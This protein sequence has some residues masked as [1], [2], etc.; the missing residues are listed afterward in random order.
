MK[1]S[2]LCT[3]FVI[4]LFFLLG[5]TAVAY[6]AAPYDAPYD[7]HNAQPQQYVRTQSFEVHAGQPG[8]YHI[9]INYAAVPGHGD[10]LVEVRVGDE[11]VPGAEAIAFARTFVDESDA[12]RTQQGNQVFPSQI[13]IERFSDFT[14]AATT[15]RPISAWLEA[16]Y[17]NLTF[18]VLEG[19]L[20]FDGEPTATLAETLPTYA[21]YNRQHANI[22]RIPS[23][24]IVIQAQEAEYKTSAALFPVNDRTCP[25]VTPYHH[26][27]ITLN[28]IGGNAWRVPGQRIQWAV[29]VP[30]AGMYRIAIRYVQREKRGFSSR[31]LSI[32]GEIPFQEAAELR[33]DFS[34]GFQSRF[35]AC[36]E[37]GEDFWFY[38][39]AGENLIGLEATL[40][41]FYEI[42]EIATQLL[43]DITRIYQEI[44]VIT[45]PTPDR[46]RDYQILIQ[47]PYFRERLTAQAEVIDYL[48]YRIDEAALGFAET[49]AILIRLHNHIT[50]LAA[51]PYRVNTYLSE[52]QNS[53]TALG[54]FITGAYE[55][56]LLIDVMGL[57]GE[58]AEGFRGR[59][60]V[61]RRLWHQL[62]V[63]LGS[64]TNDFSFDID[65][66][67]GVDPT[68]IE[69][70]V[71]TGFD[72]YSILIRLINERFVE[73]HPHINVDLRLVDAG[74]IFPAS[75][76]GT[77]P[78]VV[79]QAQAAMPINFAFRA[80][81]VDLTQFAGFDEVASRFAPAALETM[82]FRDAVYGLPDQMSFPV[83]FYRTDIL[84]DIGIY[85]PPSSMDELLGIV[86]ILQARHMDIFFTTVPQPQPGTGGGMV[87]AVTRQLNAVHVGMLHQMGGRAFEEDGAYTMV[88]DPIGI[89]AFRFWTDLYT[90]HNF[91]Y[92]ADAMT[93]FRMGDMPIVVTDLS[94]LNWINLAAPEIRGLW[95]I[96]PVPGMHNA[97]T[98]ELRHD[99]VISVSSNFIVGNMATRNDTLQESWEFLQ[100]FT[101]EEVQHRFAIDVEAVWGHNWRHTTANLAA[102]ERLGWGRQ[103][104]PVLDY[105]MD[106]LIAIPQVPGGY[107][108][109]REVHNAF[110]NVVVENGNPIDQL[111]IAR[112]RINRELTLKR[113]EFGLD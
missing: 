50:R 27:F 29:Y 86:P 48:L 84:A 23:D 92:L 21:E 109:G 13:E 85:Q 74:I 107:I 42:I 62:R 40:G 79:L 39:P 12:W 2:K 24:M 90:K 52:F 41:L 113:T 57:A 104:A 32:N 65:M 11:T 64:F 9:T 7:T 91:V 4:A 30:E 83:M 98:G 54:S 93:R 97:S 36:P 75:V 25:L 22:Q 1:K 96:A 28:T 99:T 88:A 44:V 17:N 94:M 18:V 49:N 10:I 37:T 8:Y 87:G 6:A 103:V 26:T 112:D 16:G 68:N 66:P 77:G 81:A 58:D 56:P 102:F 100:W 60:N 31:A 70:W 71:A 80:G 3:G 20:V 33:F 95:N 111:F 101:S 35:L 46:H 72:V 63:F 67:A 82:S 5:Y 106:W 78:D 108:A 55:Q 34:T 43:L 14:L 105:V 69:V 45:G 51:R 15:A 61:L 19:D 38:L 89:E 47:F 76:A 110:I 59:A 73:S 53:I